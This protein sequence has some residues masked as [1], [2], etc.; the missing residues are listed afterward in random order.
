[1]LPIAAQRRTEVYVTHFIVDLT[2]NRFLEACFVYKYI[3]M[4]SYITYYASADIMVRDFATIF[5]L[6]AHTIKRFPTLY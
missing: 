1:V 6:C 3:E 5:V 2:L 4:F